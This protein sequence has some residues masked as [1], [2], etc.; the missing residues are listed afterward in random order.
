MTFSIEYVQSHFG[1]A[2]IVILIALLIYF[3]FRQEKSQTSSLRVVGVALPSSHVSVSPTTNQLSVINKPFE[4]GF[5]VL[6]GVVSDE[7]A[8]GV[9]LEFKYKF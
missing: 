9:I 4:I 3:C 2:I 1:K 5:G 8:Y 6:G 7:P